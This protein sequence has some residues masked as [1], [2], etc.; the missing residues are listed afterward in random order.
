MKEI[1]KPKDAT[2]FVA[3][4]A[5]G[6]VLHK[7]VTEP[8]Q[9]TSTGQ[10]V[11]EHSADEIEHIQHLTPYVA[12]LEPLPAQ[13]EKLLA[14]DIYAYQGEVLIVRQDHIRTHHDP[15]TVPALFLRQNSTKDWVEGEKVHEGT[16]RDYGGKT[17]RA[18]QAHVTQADWTPDKT[19]A[20]WAEVVASTT[21][22]S[23]GQAVKAGDE[24]T[25]QGVLYV[26]LQSHN[27]LPGWEPPK[28][29]ALWRVA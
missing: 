8:N 24:R 14:G 18:I 17:Y 20:L 25:Y 1:V 5:D 15:S 27:T 9:I 28:V 13:G 21:E 26:C 11:L 29:P 16:E 7:G 19:P 12:K 22:W 2:F 10:P 23:A 4:S 6:S 3:R